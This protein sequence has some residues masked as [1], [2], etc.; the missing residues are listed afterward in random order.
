MLGLI[1]KDFL[2]IKSN[3][4]TLAIIFVV[5]AVMAFQGQMDLSF[6]LPFMSVMIMISTFSYEEFNKW[7]AYACTLPNGRE[8]TVKAKYISTILMI[9]IVTFIVTITTFLITYTKDNTINYESI[10]STMLGTFFATVLLQSFMY[11]AI[12][13]LGV[14]KARI[15]IFVVVFGLGIIGD[16]VSKIYDLK[17]VLALLKPLEN[18]VIFIIPIFMIVMLYISYTISKKTNLKKEF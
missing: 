3:F 14:E 11:P 4:K 5:Y 13:K 7:N 1:K 2:M 9:V 10:L 8:N 12:Y 18:Y 17:K 15:G 6:I 16:L